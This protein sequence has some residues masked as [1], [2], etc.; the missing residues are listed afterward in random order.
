MKQSSMKNELLKIC[1]I[2]FGQKEKPLPNFLMGR[3][4]KTY[5][6]TLEIEWNGIEVSRVYVVNKEVNSKITA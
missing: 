3:G 5:G 1:N 2:C 6:E 4:R